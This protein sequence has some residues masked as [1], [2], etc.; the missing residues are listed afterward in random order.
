MTSRSKRA[1]ALTPAPSP[2]MRL[3]E[4]PSLTMATLAVAGLACR[5]CASTLGQL[6]SVLGLD[7][8]PSVIESPNATMVPASA[9][10]ATSTAETQ[11]QVCDIA[12]SVNSGAEVK[13]PSF[14][15]QVVRRAIEWALAGPVSPGA[16]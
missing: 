9:G 11:Y 5:R 6:R 10:A 15:I 7:V 8:A 16:Y 1:R 14:E 3:P 12:A 13:S 2:R 4:M